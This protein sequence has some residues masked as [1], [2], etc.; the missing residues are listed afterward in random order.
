MSTELITVETPEQICGREQFKP[1]YKVFSETGKELNFKGKYLVG[2]NGTVIALPKKT[3]HHNMT[4]FVCI[5]RPTKTNHLQIQLM[6]NDGEKVFVY[7][8]RL[9]AS[10]WL[11]RKKW[12]TDVMH[13][14]DNPLNNNIY[15]IKWCTH[16]E[17]MQDKVRKGRHRGNKIKYSN[18]LCM[19]VYQQ[20]ESGKSVKEL[21]VLYPD[22][23]RTVL[24]HMTSGHILK[25]R[26]IIKV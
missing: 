26:G 13:L 23:S 21:M 11:K 18:E 6:N 16:L 10:V 9:V 14:D 2:N 3:K 15:N 4:G 25:Q 12:Q 5:P 8:H 24:Y 17:N 22:I 7:I 19:E 20:R 1:L